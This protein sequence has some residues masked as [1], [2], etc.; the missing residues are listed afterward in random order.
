M[1]G[2]LE[3]WKWAEQ[4]AINGWMAR[5]HLARPGADHHG[6]AGIGKV[7]FERVEDGCRYYEVT[8]MIRTDEE[9]TW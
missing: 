3:S 4:Q 2:T 7:G 1:C 5:Y 9:D 6:D 8:E